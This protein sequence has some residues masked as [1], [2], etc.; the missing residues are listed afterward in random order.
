MEKQDL[1][2]YK[3]ED[4]RTSVALTAR[5]GMIWPTAKENNYGEFAI[6]GNG[7]F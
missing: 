6:I 1:I 7:G 4:G 5:A 3:T 2:I